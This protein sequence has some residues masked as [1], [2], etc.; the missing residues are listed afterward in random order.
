MGHEMRQQAERLK[1]K[2]TG[3]DKPKAPAMLAPMVKQ[4]TEFMDKTNRRQKP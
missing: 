3:G 4:V 2:R 1:A